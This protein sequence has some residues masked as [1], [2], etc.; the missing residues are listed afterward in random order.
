MP[1]VR[2]FYQGRE[3]LMLSIKA[4]LLR[5]SEM[6]LSSLTLLKSWMR[7]SAS[8][9]MFDAE[10]FTASSLRIAQA[11]NEQGET[12]CMCP[13][14]TVFLVSAYAV[15][16]NTTPSEAQMAGDILDGA[17]ARIAQQQGIQKLLIVVPK[18][19]PALP[20]EEYEQVRVYTRRIPQPL[21]MQGVGC[22]N[23]TSAYIN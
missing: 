6:S 10:N 18:D 15:S 4:T 16:P 19:H 21:A 17:I 3:N 14:E 2:A 23:A 20:E 13:I 1:N 8:F 5:Y 22:F 11:T 12:L 9:N 7:R